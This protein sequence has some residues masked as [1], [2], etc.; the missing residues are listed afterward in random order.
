MTDPNTVKS[1]DVNAEQYNAHVLDP[2]DSIF[3]SYYEKPALRA[4]LLELNDKDVLC[5]GCGS[6][7]DAQW[8]ADQGANV[9]GIDISEG[10][11]AIGK[12]DRPDLNLQVMDMEELAFPDDTFDVA[13]SSL[14]VHYLD[15][16]TPA[17]QEARRVLKPGG[18]YVLSSMHPI[19]S[20]MN[21]YDEDSKKGARLDWVEDK[22]TQQRTVHGDYMA[23]SGDGTRPV[24]G[25]LGDIDVTAYH[26]TFSTMFE[27]ITASG[28]KIEKVIEPRPLEELK[29]IN[30]GIYEQLI[31]LPSF[32]I[33][34]LTKSV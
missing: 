7:V 1:Y 14:A 20:S 11:I 23:A 25:Y 13:C 16:M 5:I 8:L 29:E 21:M 28:F 34:V 27:Q 10:L 26:R 12:R 18:S 24:I 33:W 15:T 3:H 4:E 17:L 6:G 31:K 19:D 9:T 22:D 30:P 2:N 32:I